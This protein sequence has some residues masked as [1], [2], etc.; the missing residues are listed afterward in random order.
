ML[1]IPCCVE[2][3]KLI[4]NCSNTSSELNSS[5][6]SN[7]FH[8]NNLVPCRNVRSFCVAYYGHVPFVP[9][10]VPFDDNLQSFLE[11]TF[12]LRLYFSLHLASSLATVTAAPRIARHTFPTKPFSPL[13]YAPNVQ[14]NQQKGDVHG[15]RLSGCI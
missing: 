7:P 14:T 10:V 12:G 15:H 11:S 9:T 6:S 2:S 8:K 1:Y 13:F 3:T 4:E 5:N